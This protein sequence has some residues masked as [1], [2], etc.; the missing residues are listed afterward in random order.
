MKKFAKKIG[1][2]FALLITV[3]IL[4]VQVR[5]SLISNQTFKTYP[6]SISEDVAHG[7][8]KLG[9][10]IFQVRNG[11]VECHGKDLSG[12]KVME[13]GPMGK[14]WGH[15][16]T[17]FNLK[18]WTDEEIARAIRYG[19][20]KTGR[21]LRF[22]PSFDFEGLSKSDL[23]SLIAYLRSMPSV[24]KPNHDNTFGPIAKIMSVM[25][26]MPVMFPAL[27]IDQEKG[28][29]D[30]PPEGATP[31]FGKYLA[32]SCVGCHNTN[33]T[34]GK[35]PGG[36]PSWPE[37]AN[38][39]LGANPMWTEIKFNEMI[40]TGISV[41]HGKPVRAPMPLPLLQQLN[42]TEL[43]ALWIFLSSLK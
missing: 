10:R 27:I 19:V 8:I 38:I 9:E 23:A 15:N 20:H 36:D 42:P 5:F 18:S 34:G 6:I 11:C 29:A 21:S 3:V 12:Q 39:R 2:T 28:F 25:G 40:K 41:N 32:N 30:K 35:I 31:E 16:I 4:V 33:F 26:K 13:N 22:M 7:D 37:A 14:I 43:K 24:E 1:I 17:P